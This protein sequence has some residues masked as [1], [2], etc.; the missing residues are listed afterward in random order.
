VL[1]LEGFE[2]ILITGGMGFIGIRTARALAG[3]D[4]MVLGYHRS[5]RSQEELQSLIPAKVETVRLDVTSPYSVARAMAQFRPDSVVHLAVPH[6]GAMPPAEES[7]ANVQGLMNILEAACSAGVE[8][9][10]LA[11]S[12][13]VYA[14]LTDGPFA[15]DRALP[16]ESSS[17]T[18]AMKKA[19]EVLALHHADRTGLDLRVLRIGA[20]YGPLYHTMANLVSRL[21]HL[22][23][24]GKLPGG[25]SS[26]WTAQQIGG[27]DM[28]HVDDCASAIAAI[29]SAAKTR[30]RVY[31]V[32]GG[33]SVSAKAILA[34]VEAAVPGAVLPGELRQS[35]ASEKADGYMDI[36]RARD[37]FGIL[38]RYDIHSGIRQ[39]ADWLREHEL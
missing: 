16:V 37:E 15:E 8:R 12:V 13:A 32:G 10:S 7:L 35:G 33:A 25:L 28:I 34:A 19:E 26:G 36:T 1:H 39:Y 23:V 38:P 11:S 17:P 24:R 21:T 29:H 30:H 14:G 31:N 27:M 9:V 18:S 20:T 4:D 2:M 22:A 3:R 5:V 6:L